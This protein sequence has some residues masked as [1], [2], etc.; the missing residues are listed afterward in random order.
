MEGRGQKLGRRGGCGSL[1]QEKQPYGD[2]PGPQSF[3]GIWLLTCTPTHTHF[4]LDVD[5]KGQELG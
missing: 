1:T 3:S 4:T 2:N 5:P